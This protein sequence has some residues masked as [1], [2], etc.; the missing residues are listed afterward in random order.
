MIVVIDYDMG[1]VGSI[2]NMIKKVGG[3]CIVTRDPEE[4]EKATKLILPGVGA[5]DTGVSN[6]AKYSLTDLLDRKVRIEKTPILGICLGMQLLGL[7]SEEG[8]LRSFGW[9]SAKTVKFSIDSNL[10][11]PHMGWNE[12]HVTKNATIFNDLPA[13]KRFYF[14]HSYHLVC[15]DQDDVIATTE[16]GI[17]FNSAVQRGNIIGTQF[18]PEKSHKYGMQLMSNFVNKI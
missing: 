5:F 4:I 17:S 14:V 13:V 3:E 6:I 2:A 18:H 16:Y 1:N 15:D 12:I 9:L 8:N 7:A 10:K 11:V